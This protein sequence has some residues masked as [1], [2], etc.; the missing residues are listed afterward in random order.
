VRLFERSSPA[1]INSS[2]ALTAS[3]VEYHR[4]GCG[5]L[6]ETSLKKNL[7][8]FLASEMLLRLENCELKELGLMSGNSTM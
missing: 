1:L 6:A 2:S 7:G 8:C 3:F 4:C 5:R